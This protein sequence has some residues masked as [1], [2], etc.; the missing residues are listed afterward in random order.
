MAIYNFLVFGQSL[1]NNN[2]HNS[3]TSNDIDMKLGPVDMTR[4]NKRNIETQQHQTNVTGK[5]CQQIMNS[6]SI[7]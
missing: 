5:S 7:F 1:I 2:C 3:R 4:H 6:S